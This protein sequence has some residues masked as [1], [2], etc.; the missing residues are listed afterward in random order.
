M[1][2]NSP[3]FSTL[4]A[5]EL[6]DRGIEDREGDAYFRFKQ[7][8]RWMLDPI[9]PVNIVQHTVRTQGSYTDPYTG[10]TIELP[11]KRVMIQMAESDSVVPNI[12]TEILSERMG[13]D[14]RLYTP[15]IS[16]HGFLFDP[17]SGE[18]RRAR[19]DMIEFFDAR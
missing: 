1:M 7:I 2:E 19:N 3:A 10:E 14:Y 13:I 12:T 15:S 6:A 9:D 17:A 4:Y 18:G 5:R 16:N 8:L 11:F